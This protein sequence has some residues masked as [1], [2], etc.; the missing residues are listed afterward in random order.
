LSATDCDMLLVPDSAMRAS[1]RLAAA[2]GPL[3][4]LDD[5]GPGAA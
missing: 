4:T 2:R 1:R 5:P 3:A